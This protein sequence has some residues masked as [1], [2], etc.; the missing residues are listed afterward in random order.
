MPKIN[1][2]LICLIS[3]MF[4][5]GA[6]ALVLWLLSDPNSDDD[7]ENCPP[8]DKPSCIYWPRCRKCVAVLDHEN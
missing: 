6:I 1:P 4:V 2:I 8:W 3:L 5:L 7:P